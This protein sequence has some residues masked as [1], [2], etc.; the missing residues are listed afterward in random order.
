M[1]HSRLSQRPARLL[2]GTLIIV[3][4]ACS[5]RAGQQ[6]AVDS[7]TSSAAVSPAADSTVARDSSIARDPTTKKPSDTS[8]AGASRTDSV[9]GTQENA[10]EGTPMKPK[11]RPNID[12]GRHETKPR[13]AAPASTSTDSTAATQPTSSAPAT[14]PASSGQQEQPTYDAKTNT[15]TFQLIGGPSGF[16]FNGY[17]SG[18]ATLTLPGNANVLIHFVNKDGTPH[19]A[20]VISGEGP[21][22][23]AGGDPAIP[24]A[25]TNKLSEG[26]PQE[27]SDDMRFTVPA[28][29]KYRIFCGVPGHGLS[30]MWIWMVVD[31]AAKTPSFG[32]TKS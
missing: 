29:G 31:P 18:G 15:V 11:V 19:S 8:M 6:P 16:Q 5:K 25:Y 2:A 32:P 30:G 3:G 17:S 20:E 12:P 22:P 7:G 24:R 1:F 13:A 9:R 14:Q 23:N 26:L 4:S 28:S 10:A 27:A 21:I